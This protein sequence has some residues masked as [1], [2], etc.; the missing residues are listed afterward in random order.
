MQPGSKPSDSFNDTI[1]VRVR[2][3]GR[4]SD[5]LRNGFSYPDTG[6]PTAV[7]GGVERFRFLCFEDEFHSN[8]VEETRGRPHRSP[9]CRIVMMHELP[10]GKTHRHDAAYHPVIPPPN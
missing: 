6:T 1:F 9:L 2:I 8:E 3:E 7:Y 10:K 5:S 4:E